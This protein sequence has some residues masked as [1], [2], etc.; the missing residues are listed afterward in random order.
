MNT[1][2]EVVLGELG[3][4]EL[5]ARRD[6]AKLK[7]LKRLSDRAKDDYCRF[8]T[9]SKDSAWVQEVELSWPIRASVARS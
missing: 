9:E 1:A 7:M 3:W 8:L 6:K 4:W 5:R 2:N